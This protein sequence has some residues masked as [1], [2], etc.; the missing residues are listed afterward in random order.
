MSSGRSN[1]RR[2][3]VIV[4]AP[5]LATFLLAAAVILLWRRRK[6]RNNKMKNHADKEE[7]VEEE[8]F[9]IPLFDLGRIAE[10]VGD[11]FFDN[12]LR[13]GGFGPIYS[14]DETIGNT[15]GIVGT[16]GYMSLEY[17]M[18]GIFPVKSNA[19]SFGV[20]VIEVI[21]SEKNN[22]AYRCTHHQN[23][24]GESEAMSLAVHF[25][26][27]VRASKDEGDSHGPRDVA[28]LLVL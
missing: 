23:L 1:K 4:V 26:K 21:T 14:G 18:N 28:M 11:F 25:Q 2:V 16:Y 10:A 8:N 6:T 13:E 5:L 24:L 19:F 9:G 20:L 22:G 12:K 17:A 3:A 15:E 7:T 27:K